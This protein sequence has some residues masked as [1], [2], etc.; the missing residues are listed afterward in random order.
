MKLLSIMRP[1]AIIAAALA[2]AYWGLM[3]IGHYPLIV[4]ADS[5]L[6]AGA[7]EHVH[8]ALFLFAVAAGTILFASK[9]F[10]LVLLRIALLLASLAILALWPFQ[11]SDTLHSARWPLMAIISLAIAAEPIESRAIGNRPMAMRLQLAI[12]LLFPCAVIFLDWQARIYCGLLPSRTLPRQLEQPGLHTSIGL[13]DFDS[14][15]HAQSS[16]STGSSPSTSSPMAAR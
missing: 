3:A 12:T 10:P 6:G 13:M 7:M 14:A 2:A 8:D 15:A 9:L 11:S 5:D 4:I 16:A 1:I